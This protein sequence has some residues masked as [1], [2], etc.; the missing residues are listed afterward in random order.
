MKGTTYDLC[1]CNFCSDGFNKNKHF[2]FLRDF[3]EHTLLIVCNFS[4]K[5]AK[6]NL[7]IPEHAFEWMEIEISENLNPSTGIQVSVPAM[8]ARILT[9]I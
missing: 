6:M 4:D 5:D 2:A 1:Y 7:Q 3:Q 8:D 9:L